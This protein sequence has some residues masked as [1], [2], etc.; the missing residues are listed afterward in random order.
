M[1]VTVAFKWARDPQDA[2]AGHNGAVVW[3]SAKM[4]AS[5]DDSAAM[6]VAKSIS[7]EEDIKAV[8]VGDGDTAWAAARG[9]SSTVSISNVQ[10]AIDGGAVASALAAGIKRTGEADW[11]IVGDTEWD[12]AVVVALAGKLGLPAYAGV[13][14]V[15][16]AGNR[17][18]ITCKSGSASRVV[19]IRGPALLAVKGLS[20]EKNTPA[21]KQILQARKKPQDKVNASEVDSLDEPKAEVCGTHVPDAAGVIMFNAEDPDSAACELVKALRGDGVL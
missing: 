15:E 1:K 17:L 3:G 16:P 9:A 10:T 4:A 19:E 20:A 7:L 6:D 13:T 5:D 14:A 18:R 11:I 2:R 21:M 12:R 8:T